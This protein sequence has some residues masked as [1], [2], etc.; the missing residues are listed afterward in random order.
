MSTSQPHKLFLPSKSFHDTV[1][2][3]LLSRF[4]LAAYGDMLAYADI[5]A[6]ALIANAKV[7]SWH[8]GN[9]EGVMA[10]CAGTLIIGLAGSNDAA[11]AIQDAVLVRQKLGDWGAAS[12]IDVHESAADIESTA[13]FLAYTEM[14][15]IGIL[16]AIEE[17]EIPF[18][19]EVWLCG[20]SLG[21]VA[22]YLLSQTEF[23][24]VSLARRH[25]VTYGAPRILGRQTAQPLAVHTVACRRLLDFVPYHPTRF[26]HPPAEIRLLGF[27]KTIHTK[28][29]PLYRPLLW[30][31]GV[32]CWIVGYVIGFCGS[33]HH[34]MV[35]YDDD[36]KPRRR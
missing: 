30:C 18:V 14:C 3:A 20:H 6:G 7:M 2:A 32:A 1:N 22:A 33:G 9:A 31:A 25:V 29:P 24:P 21:G 35:K 8:N 4:A 26:M 12:G 10:Y 5:Q 13:G 34:S 36:L 11:D 15:A 23:L 19:R 27:G 28:V 16:E 17:Y